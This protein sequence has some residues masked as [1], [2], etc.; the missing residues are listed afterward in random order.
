M[1]LIKIS[2]GTKVKF[3]GKVL[4]GVTSSEGGG[5]ET[6]NALQFEGQNLQYNGETLTFTEN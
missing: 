5:N 6:Q 4:A 3:E 2:S 1:S